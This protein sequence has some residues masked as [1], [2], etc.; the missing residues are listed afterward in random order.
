VTELP[1]FPAGFLWGASTAAYQI[2]GAATEGGRGPS[3][4]D[5]FSHTADRTKDS[6]TGDAACDHYHRFAED[7]ALLAD[8]GADAYRFSIAWPRIQ[9][10]GT[11]PANAEGLDFYDRLTDALIE[12]GITPLPTLFH[13]DLPQPLEDKGGWLDRETAHRFAE[14]T[15]FVAD[16]LGDRIKLWTSLNFVGWSRRSGDRRTAAAAP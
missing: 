11:G 6:D 12:H 10:D 1:K 14:Y 5:T 3:I 8:L 4:W 7:T 13:W 9:P 15:M 16:R 2:E